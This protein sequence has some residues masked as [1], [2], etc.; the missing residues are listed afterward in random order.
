MHFLHAAQI[1][2]LHNRFHS[3]KPVCSLCNVTIFRIASRTH[4]QREKINE[5][6]FRSKWLNK[7]KRKRNNNKQTENQ[8]NW[9]ETVY[10]GWLCVL[11]CDIKR[12]WCEES[13][14]TLNACTVHIHMYRYRT[15][16]GR[17][18]GAVVPLTWINTRKIEQTIK[19]NGCYQM[20][21]N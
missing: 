11:K 1:R 12:K 14:Q 16:N 4:T 2:T 5:I 7:T 17:R 3:L 18:S 19:S 8:W 13:K 21:L 15:A 20:V 10:C 6:V 9:R